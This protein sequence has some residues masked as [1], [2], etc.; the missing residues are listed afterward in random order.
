VQN[1][2]VP[3]DQLTQIIQMKGIQYT[4]EEIQHYLTVGGYPPLDGDYTV[5]GQVLE[6][7]DVVDKIALAQRDTRDRPLENI[8]MKVKVISE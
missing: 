8:S 6:G 4:P 1:G 5:F 3:Q 2:P 7:L